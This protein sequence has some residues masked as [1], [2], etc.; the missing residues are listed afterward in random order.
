MEKECCNRERVIIALKSIGKEELK[1]IIEEDEKAEVKC[2]YC[3]KKY[4]FTKIELEE[5]LKQIN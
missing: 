1:L 5:I 3:N 4:N 2:P